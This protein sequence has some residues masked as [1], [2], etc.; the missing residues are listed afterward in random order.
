MKRDRIHILA[1]STALFATSASIIFLLSTGES[2][3]T[4]FLVLAVGLVIYGLTRVFH[5]GGN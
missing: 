2:Y 5:E 3:Q 1:S 4:M